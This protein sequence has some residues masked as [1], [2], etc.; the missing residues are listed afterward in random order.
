MCD[1]NKSSGRTKMNEQTRMAT[2]NG[3]AVVE[4]MNYV[5][6]DLY[7]YHVCLGNYFYNEK[8]S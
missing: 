6:T 7:V 8:F 5:Y 1:N 4:P 2:G 3:K